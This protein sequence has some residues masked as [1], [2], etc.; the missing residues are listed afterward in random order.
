MFIRTEV[1]HG[2]QITKQV[3][4]LLK[5][6]ITRR[7]VCKNLL[8]VAITATRVRIQCVQNV[9]KMSNFGVLQVPALVFVKDV[10]TKLQQLGVGE[11]AV[12]ARRDNKF[13]ERDFVVVVFIYEAENRIAEEIALEPDS[14]VEIVHVQSS[15]V[16]CVH[17]LELFKK[18]C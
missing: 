3:I 17:G 12:C 6:Q 9:D 14:I 10:E 5:I 2:L 7:L 18:L 13:V 8:D 4:N 11:G 16:H 1:L 15:H